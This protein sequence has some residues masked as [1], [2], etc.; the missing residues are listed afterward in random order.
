[1]AALTVLQACAF[2]T[3]A[4]FTAVVFALLGNAL[5]D[6]DFAIAIRMSTNLFSH[7][8]IPPIWGRG[9]SHATPAKNWGCTGLL[10]APIHNA[11][12]FCDKSL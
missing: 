3:G 7:D 5:A 1:M 4:K 10:V 11:C 8:L 12:G 9:S 6:F 2:T